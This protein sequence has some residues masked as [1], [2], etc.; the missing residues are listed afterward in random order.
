VWA[1]AYFKYI[2]A[3]A[4]ILALL[5]SVGITFLLARRIVR[6][7]SAAA[8][9]A[10]RIAGGQLDTPIPSGGRDETGI[11]LRS[12]SVMQANI[13]AMMQRETA[14]RRSAQKR[15]VDALESS[16]EG[17]IL[18]DTD[19]KIVIANS[20]VETF[21]PEVAPFITAGADFAT[22]SALFA[23]QL[24]R[25]G[26]RSN[27]RAGQTITAQ[28]TVGEHQLANGR[29]IRVSRSEI[30]DGGYFL[31]LSDF[32]DIKEREEHYRNAK[33]EAEAANTAKTK[34]LANMSH[35]LRTPLNAIIGFSE[36][37]ANQ[38]FGAIGNPKYVEFASD[39][40]RSGHHLLEIINSVL[41]LAKS[42]SKK[43]TLN[44]EPVDLRKVIEDC[45]TMVSEQC[46]HAKLHLEVMRSEEP[47]L[48]F[49]EPAK[50]RQ[51]VLN[52]LSNAIKFTE[53]GGRVWITTG[54]SPSG[55]YELRVSDS[56]IGMSETDIQIALAPF[57]QVDGSLT[58]RH[59][60]TGLGL[61]LTKAFAE[62]HGGRMTIASEPGKGTTVIVALPRIRPEKNGQPR[63][64]SA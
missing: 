39:I 33:Q 62:L 6:P 51:I 17:M 36:L 38:L 61:P 12:M 2:S 50:L 44:S 47:L 32:T 49:G 30:Q 29:W 20:Q 58:R 46:A 45:S 59:E 5:S 54:L 63:I 3:G 37:I 53:P 35:E 60:G 26:V 11:L 64:L 57:G 43:L 23:A 21:F 7:L 19:G 55:E 24:R 13:R 9:V 31:F 14:Q 16:Q 27:I 28:L 34:F 18:V 25:S 22:T 1:I 52:L 42:E 48:V 8:S 10:D 15:L 40:L 56:G 41:D 4:L